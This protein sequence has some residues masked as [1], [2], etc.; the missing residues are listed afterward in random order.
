MLG[1]CLEIFQKKLKECGESLIL[2]E[3][4][5]KDGT[6][7]IV[8][9]NGEITSVTDIKRDKK[10]GKISRSASR[11]DDICYYDYHSDLISM[12]KPQDPA[13]IVH[14][15][16]YLCFWVKKESI[17]NG[18][19]KPE[20]IEKYY[21]VLENPGKK[22]EKSKAAPIYQ[23]LEETLGKV[24]T[25][26]LQR[27]KQ[28]ILEHI[29]SVEELSDDIDMSRKDYL[30]IFFEA[31]REEYEREGNRYVLPNIYN[32]NNYNVEVN[33]EIL[34][35][36]DNNQGMNAKKPFLSVKTR[37]SVAPYLLNR[38]EV[39]LQKQFFD[40][41]MNFASVGKNN[42]YVDLNQEE[43]IPC[44]DGKYPPG[45]ISG[46]YL[47]LQKGKEVEI[48]NQDVVPF[49]N[50][51]LKE[52]FTYKN[53]LEIED[54]H[55]PEYQYDK[56]CR[57]YQELEETVNDIFFSKMLINNYFSAEE[58]IRITD[59][60]LKEIYYYPEEGCLNGF[61]WEIPEE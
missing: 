8:G 42:L 7:I 50:N 61:V 57:T 46:F 27:N 31:D 1:E 29:F 15:N 26:T 59:D 33:G 5:L 41:L 30:K 13:K 11:Y 56:E 22:Y 18:K 45:A 38:Q 35:L 34:G 55:E 28:W 14:S 10:S 48:Q 9:K 24:D 40:Y 3:Y 12:N 44:E 37:K 19:L 23:K 25:E 54:E 21:D 16:N 20:V 51:K 2:D 39:I 17:S 43:F 36:P 58:N 6:Y 47:R 32:S 53:V 49:F 52:I 4:V 60:Y